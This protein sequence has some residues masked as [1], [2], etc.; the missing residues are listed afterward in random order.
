MKL[1]RFLF[2]LALATFTSVCVGQNLDFLNNK[3]LS[4]LNK[5][6]PAFTGILNQFRILSNKGEDFTLGF[7][8]RIAG[9]KNF[10]GASYNQQIAKSINSIKTSP[11]LGLKRNGLR[12][13]FARDIL[14][15]DKLQLK[16]GGDLNTQKTSTT[17]A[18]TTDRFGIVDFSGNRYN[19]DTS[20]IT[21]IKYHLRTIDVSLGASLLYRNLVLG[22][23]ARHLTTPNISM[24]SASKTKLPVEV[25]AELIGFVNLSQSFTL[26]PNLIASLK[27]RN[28]Y[29]G[30]TYASLG[31]GILYKNV[32]F[33]G[34]LIAYGATN[35]LDLGISCRYKRYYINLSYLSNL[36]KLYNSFGSLEGLRITVNTSLF[37]IKKDDD[38]IRDY[39]KRIY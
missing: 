24:N 6:N 13:S 32:V 3:E 10:I 27:K 4:K 21:D 2:F 11:I 39:L 30:R 29:V 14:Q 9:G 12:I 28:D 34:R 16:V 15:S 22:L 20:N 26:M 23:S 19:F 35:A 31:I 18:A 1:F 5:L 36:S 37:K 17:E 33:N 38:S 7:E 25:T 8:S